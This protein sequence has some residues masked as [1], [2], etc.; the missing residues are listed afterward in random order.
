MQT[1]LHRANALAT[2][3]NFLFTQIEVLLEFLL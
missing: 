2:K 1:D 3:D